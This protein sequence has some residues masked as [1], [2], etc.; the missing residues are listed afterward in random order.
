MHFIDLAAQQRRIRSDLEARLI[1]V[2]DHNIYIMGPEVD[3]LE[4]RL[5]RFAGAKHCVG[6]ASGTDALFIALLAWG[7]GPGQA[8][9]VP[10]FTFFATAEVVALLGATPIMVDI[11]PVSFNMDPR[12][13]E[14]ALAAVETGDASIYPLPRQARENRLEAR[15]VIFVDLFGQAADYQTLL[16]LA[17][18]HG[19]LTLEDAAQAFGAEY[20]GEKTCALGCDAGATSFFPAKPL[21]AYGDGGALFTEDDELAAAYRSI[22]FHGKGRDR[23]EHVRLGVNGR[24]DTL[25]AAVLLSKLEIFPEEIQARQRVAQAYAKALA[26]VPGLTLPRISPHCLSVWAQYCVLASG[27]RRDGLAARLKEK[28][29]PTAI[30]YPAP[31]HLMQV[32]QYLGYSRDAFPSALASSGEILALP[33]H[34][35][36]AEEEIARVA[37]AVAEAM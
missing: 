11:D 1:A 37:E 18:K 22:L 36:L 16:P 34:P 23:Y 5:A 10:A 6:C 27:G 7:V 8:V 14:K 9:F 2:L 17:Q 25:Q 28:N 12:S 26:P 21:G 19:L 30:Y 15:A 33:F 29:I 20:R 3:E 4:G 24:L 31:L 32:F 13:L 35:Y